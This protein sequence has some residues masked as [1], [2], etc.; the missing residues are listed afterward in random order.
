MRGSFERSKTM[1][2]GDGR[3]ERARR[4]STIGGNNP[5]LSP[6][7]AKAVHFPQDDLR[8]IP[9]AKTADSPMYKPGINP[10]PVLLERIRHGRVER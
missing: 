1:G 4:I 2:G 7:P 6:K 9:A 5:E 10:R 3:E 8:S